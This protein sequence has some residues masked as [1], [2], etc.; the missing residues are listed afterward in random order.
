MYY[1]LSGTVGGYVFLGIGFIFAIIGSIFGWKVSNFFIPR[2][3]FY[4][5]SAATMFGVKLGIAAGIG[6]GLAYLVLLF[7]A[8]VIDLF[9]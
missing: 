4:T 1:I 7:I 3:D 2:R 6:I 9:K 5:K 8:Y